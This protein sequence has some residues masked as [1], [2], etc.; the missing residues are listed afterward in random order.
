MRERGGALLRSRDKNKVQPWVHTLAQVKGA[1][2]NSAF[3]N[4]SYLVT[5]ESEARILLSLL[6]IAFHCTEYT[7][8]HL[9]S[10]RVRSV[11]FA[12]AT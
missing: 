4:S 3:F 1:F 5:S 12:Q 11:G 7:C 6:E 10:R 9:F 2:F 8:W